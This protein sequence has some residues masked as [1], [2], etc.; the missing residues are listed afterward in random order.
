MGSRFLGVSIQITL[1][2]LEC[3]SRSI[4]VLNQDQ[5]IGIVAYL[6]AIA[7][8]ETQFIV[9]SCPIHDETDVLGSIVKH[10]YF[11]SLLSAVSIV[12]ACSSQVEN[13][14]RS[15][16]MP[17]GFKSFLPDHSGATSTRSAVDLLSFD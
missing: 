5:T 7:P 11:I 10:F 15:Q 4:S 8:K 6:Q 16:T 12:A 14:T 17:L 13:V 3:V 9:K 2:R 1:R